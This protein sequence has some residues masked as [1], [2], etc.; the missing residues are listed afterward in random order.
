MYVLPERE[1]LILASGYNV[2]LRAA[3][4]DELNR[5]KNL[6]NHELPETLMS[7]DCSISVGQFSRA[8][9]IMGQNRIFAFMRANKII[10][11]SGK[12]KNTPYQR[13]IDRG[14]FEVIEKLVKVGEKEK[15]TL[16]TLITPKGQEYLLNLL[17]KSI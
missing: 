7:T 10:I 8:S 9:G 17:N 6:N 3:I 2:K 16:Q 15:I 13:Y 12:K 4:I 11:S 5:M 1:C 14:Y